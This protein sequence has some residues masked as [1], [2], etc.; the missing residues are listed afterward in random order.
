MSCWSKVLGR[1]AMPARTI[2]DQAI[3]AGTEVVIERIEDGVAYV[4]QWALDSQRVVLRFDDSVI[5]AIADRFRKHFG[6]APTW[7]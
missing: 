6:L 4:E 5:A 7:A 2:D 1:R 3:A